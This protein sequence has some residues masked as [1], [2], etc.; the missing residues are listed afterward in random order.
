MVTSD[1][2]EFDQTTGEL[3]ER[4]GLMILDHVEM[5]NCSQ[6]DTYKASI[7]F[8]NAVTLSSSVTNSSFHNGLGWGANIK[9]SAKVVMQDNLWFNF[10]AIGIAIDFANNITFDNNVV[11]HIIERTTIEAGDKF[12]DKRAAVTICQYLEPETCSDIRVTN[13]IAAG[14]TYAGFIAPG[15]DCGD[16]ANSNFKGNIAHS[17]A[18]FKGGHGALIYPDPAREIQQTCYQGS[19]FTAYKCYY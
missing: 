12:V 5:Y 1:T 14:V 2:I 19:F 8:E 10:R 15:H 3:K 17:V 7:R 18:G 9:N 16:S 11:A 6:I 13:N 4:T